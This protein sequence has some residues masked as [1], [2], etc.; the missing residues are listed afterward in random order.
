MAATASA[1]SSK[2]EGPMIWTPRISPYFSSATTLTNPSCWPMMVALLFATN[3]N[4]PTLTLRP[5]A[6]ACASVCC[7]AGEQ[8]RTAVELDEL[9]H[10]SELELAFIEGQ[11]AMFTAAD[12]FPRDAHLAFVE[13][14][15]KPGV[16]QRIEAESN[17]KCR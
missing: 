4:L 1:I 14:E 13:D 5:C 16:G 6:F 11:K 3:G 10:Y 17:G 2:A 8:D 9:A 15:V 7:V 12:T